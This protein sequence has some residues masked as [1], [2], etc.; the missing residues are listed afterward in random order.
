MRVYPPRSAIRARSPVRICKHVCMFYVYAYV[1]YVLCICICIRK[2]VF[3]Y[4]RKYICVC[5]KYMC[6]YP[7]RSVILDHLCA[8]ADICIY[9]IYMCVCIYIY[10][11]VD[12]YECI[13]AIYVGTPAEKLDTRLIC[14]NICMYTHI[15]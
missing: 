6:V 8:Y 15:E 11:Y 12:K 4:T 13:R 7:P 9:I 3:A 2:C 14:E 10:I 1:L 5:T